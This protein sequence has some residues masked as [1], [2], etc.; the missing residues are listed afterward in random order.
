MYIVYIECVCVCVW[1]YVH[2]HSK[3]HL[4]SPESFI[5]F[6]VLDFWVMP[7]SWVHADRCPNQVVIYA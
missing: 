7:S 6:Q 2:T 5:Q 1:V 4:P 3:M